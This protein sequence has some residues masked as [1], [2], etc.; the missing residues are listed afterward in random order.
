MAGV[1]RATSVLIVLYF[2]TPR[3]E[4]SSNITAP[5]WDEAGFDVVDGARSR[6]RG[7]IE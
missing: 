3:S 6:H 5:I 4:L 1:Q 2:L 7:A